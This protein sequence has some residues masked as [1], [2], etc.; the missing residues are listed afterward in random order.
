MVFCGRKTRG[1]VWLDTYSEIVQVRYVLYALNWAWFRKKKTSKVQ[2]LKNQN[3][4]IE[5]VSLAQK[6]F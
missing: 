6:I 5:P 3:P 4:K 2:T 1:T